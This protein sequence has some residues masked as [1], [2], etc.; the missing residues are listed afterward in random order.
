MRPARPVDVCMEGRNCN[1]PGSRA[2]RSYGSLS[3]YLADA[4][5]GKDSRKRW[6]TTRDDLLSIDSPETFARIGI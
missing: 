6:F 1:F 4:I 2:I 5:V 3:T